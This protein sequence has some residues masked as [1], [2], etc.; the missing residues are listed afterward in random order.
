MG[1]PF[2]LGCRG[3]SSCP[4]HAALEKVAWLPPARGT[5][6]MEASAVTGKGCCVGRPPAGVLGQVCKLIGSRLRE[7]SDGQLVARFVDIGDEADLADHLARRGG[8]VQG[9]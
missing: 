9:F 4:P 5:L 8:E 1:H 3:V 6:L 2:V 7:L